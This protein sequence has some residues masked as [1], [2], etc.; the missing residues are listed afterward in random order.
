MYGGI[1]S[2]GTKWVCAVGTG[3]EDIRAAERFPTTTPA[4]TVG[5]AIEF[6]QQHKGLEAIGVGSFGPVDLQTESLTYGHITTTPKPG[7][8]FA[9]V[10]G[11]LRKAFG[12]PVGFDTDVNAAALGE[13]RW[14][15]GRGLDTFVYFTIGTGIGGGAMV[16]GRLL[17][18]MLHPE[19]GHMILPRDPARDP[20]EGACKFHGACLEGLASGPAMEQRWRARAETLPPDHPAWKIEAHYLALGVLNAISILSPQR[21]ILGGGV[22]SQSH[23]FPLIRAEVKAL[24][25]DYLKTP[26]ILER[27][28]DYI[29]PPALGERAG[30][31]GAIALA[32]AALD[33]RHSEYWL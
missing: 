25:G 20:F 11:P 31:L 5:Q 1:E 28:D 2:G 29:V 19:M 30:V 12:V 15:A 26:Q 3:P 18:G 32:E 16:N 14:G 4:E 9:D 22:M 13:H 7:W 8:Q 21:V 17:H 27:I 10:A 6:F 33:S 23:L 24:L